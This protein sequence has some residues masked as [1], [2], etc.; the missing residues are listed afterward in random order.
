M[1]G[2]HNFS[3]PR[4]NWLQL[5][6]AAA[7]TLAHGAA[8]AQQQFATP[9]DAAAALVAA[10][11][12]DDVKGVVAVLGREGRA[13][14]AS[15]DKTADKNARARFLA[16]Y[17]AKREFSQEGNKATLMIGSDSWP[18][19]VPLVKAERGWSFDA[20][21]GKQEILYRRV[22][23]NERSA[24]EVCLA[25]VDAQQDYAAMDP[26]K[27]G[28]PNYAQRVVSRPGKKDGLFWPA[29][30]GE[31]ASPFGELAAAAAREGYRASQKP[32]PYYGY[33]YKILK[34]Q[35]PAA[36]GGAYDYTARGKMIGGFAL[37]AY[38][39]AY[40]NSGVMTFIVNHDGTVFQKDLGPRTRQIASG[41]TRFDPGKSWKKV[42]AESASA[43]GAR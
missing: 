43:S 19:P 41:M 20:R 38:P 6:V 18:F 27:A 23:R 30:D 1:N 25:Y 10:A 8:A 7:L 22:G 9:E 12:F 33:Y 13:I 4:L 2:K 16:A 24:I 14:V 32:S 40:R 5:A 21:A 31:Q 36:A 26:Q 11:R 28:I 17:D 3:F 42:A 39:A 35:G 29:K 37:V 34:A 15:G